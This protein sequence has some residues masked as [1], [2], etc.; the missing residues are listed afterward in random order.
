LHLEVICIRV[1]AKHAKMKRISS[2]YLMRTSIIKD[3]EPLSIALSVAFWAN[4]G[5]I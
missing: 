1:S 4:K 5:E 3:K 2:I